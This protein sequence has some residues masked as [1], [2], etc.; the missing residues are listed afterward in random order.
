MK[1]ERSQFLVLGCMDEILVLQFT[2]Q[3]LHDTGSRCEHLA[4]LVLRRK[5]YGK[6]GIS[7]CGVVHGGFGF[8]FPLDLAGV[9]LDIASLGGNYIGGWTQNTL[10]HTLRP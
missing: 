1:E 5:G 10:Q 4:R 2:E 6:H 7:N 3:G 9:R 8:D